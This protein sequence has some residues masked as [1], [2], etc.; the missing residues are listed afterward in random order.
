MDLDRFTAILA[1]RLSAIVPAGFHVTAADGMLWYYAEEGRFPGQ[2][3]DG[4]IGP[5]GTYIRSVYGSSDEE[6]MVD[7]A[8]Q[9]LSEL[10]DYISEA[11]HAPWPGMTSQPSPEGRIVDSHLNLWYGDHNKPVLACERIPLTEAE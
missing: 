8:V 3:G 1:N 5:A 2:L 9:A 11:T 6:N 10:Q 4:R 7:V